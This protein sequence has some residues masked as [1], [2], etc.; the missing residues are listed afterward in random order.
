[1]R[2]NATLLVLLFIVACAPGAEEKQVSEVDTVQADVEFITAIWDRYDA[3]IES[4]DLEAILAIHSDDSVRMPPNEPTIIGKEG[5]RS[6]YQSLFDRVTLELEV[7]QKEIEIL[8]DWAFERGTFSIIETSK[9]DGELINDNGKW[10]I[11]SQRQPDGSWKRAR[12][13]WSSDNPIT[14]QR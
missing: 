12:A 1:M 5:I 11:M 6:W 7:S 3:A 4:G 10:V 14:G 2:L 9:G 8:G 13:I